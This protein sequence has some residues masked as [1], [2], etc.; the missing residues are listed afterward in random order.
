MRKYR[1]FIFR[2]LSNIFHF[3]YF[4]YWR[5]K[6]RKQFYNIDIKSPFKGEIAE[7][8][9]FEGEISLTSILRLEENYR[10]YPEKI[11]LSKDLKDSVKEIFSIL[12]PLVKD[13]FGENVFIDGIRWLEDKPSNK[14]HSSSSWHI[15][16]VGNR[17]KCFICIKGNGSMPTLVIPSK[18]RITSLTSWIKYTDLIC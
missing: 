8:G 15:D 11:F 5:I 10:S 6:Q 18:R 14:F 9:I 16:N 17:L 12:L 7:S 1:I 13:Y 3:L 4:P 2:F